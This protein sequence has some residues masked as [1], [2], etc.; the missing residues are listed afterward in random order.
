MM[1]LG[2]D[3]SWRSELV[4]KLDITVDD[5]ILDLS[6][7]TGDVAI[8]MAN[9]LKSIKPVISHPHTHSI[10]GLDPS[11]NMLAFAAEKIQKSNLTDYIKLIQGDAQDMNE[12][13]NG[14]F[15]KVSMSFGIRNVPY[16]LKA[17]SEIYRVM[18][19]KG[20]VIIMEFFA[21]VAENKVLSSLQ[22]S[23]VRYIVPLIGSIISNGHNDE[24]KHLSDS[25]F[26]FPSPV[27]FRSLMIQSGFPSNA[28]TV[29][30]IFFNLVYLCTCVKD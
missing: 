17:L 18:Q 8:R 29:N 16:R 4:E 1:S 11:G 5:M 23:F 25:I 28:C 24:Y 27:V 20:K 12:L 14:T 6:T 7:G 22:Q 26:A 3:E 2:F 9:K 19:P 30:S 10:I 13:E 15:S 21:P